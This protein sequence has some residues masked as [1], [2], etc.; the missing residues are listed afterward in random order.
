VATGTVK[1]FNPKRHFGFIRP[2]LGGKDIF[3]HIS[4]VQRSGVSGLRK[5]Q[6]VSFEIV[7]DQGKPSAR[8]LQIDGQKM[9]ADKPVVADSKADP[10][11]IVPEQ[12][13]PASRQAVT[14][15]ALQSVITEE[16]RNRGPQCEAFVGV[17]L[18]KVTPKSPDD[19]NWALKGV[20]FGKSDRAQC[21][22]A[23]SGIV[24]QFQQEFMILDESQ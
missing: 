15:D 11:K 4:E 17:L 19:V 8:N 9:D 24:E 23:L 6:K 14:C 16:V 22:A 12:Q 18:E 5:G 1:S 13:L 20:R 3:V 10:Q 7:D 21:A 2:D